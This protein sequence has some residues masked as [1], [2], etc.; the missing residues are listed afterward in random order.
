MSDFK[1]GD[2]VSWNS[3]A[4]ID[5]GTIIKINTKDFDYKGYTHHASPDRPQYEIKSDKSDHVAAHY[6]DKLKKINK[7]EK[8]GEL[9]KIKDGRVGGYLVGRKHSECNDDGDCGIKATNISTGQ[10][11]EVQANEVVITAPAVKDKTLHTFDG[12][13]MNNRQILSAINQSGGGVSFAEG[14][15]IKE[16]L[17][18]G[19]RINHFKFGDGTVIAIEDKGI[20]EVKFDN[21]EAKKLI[22]K[23][24]PIKKIGHTEDVLPLNIDSNISPKYTSIGELPQNEVPILKENKT[25]D[26][27]KIERKSREMQSVPVSGVKIVKETEK[28]YL[29][30]MDG[31]KGW[32]PKGW[33]DEENEDQIISFKKQ[34]Y[35]RALEGLKEKKE[36]SFTDS[37]NSEIEKETEK[38]YLIKV[39]INMPNGEEKKLDVWFPKS[40]IKL[41][42]GL[43]E[44]DNDFLKIKKAELEDKYGY[45]SAPKP[46]YIGEKSIGY[47]VSVYENLSEQSVR[48]SIYFPLSQVIKS[49]EDYLIP[50]WL[51][52]A[53]KEELYD[54]VKTGSWAMVSD[55]VFEI[56]GLERFVKEPIEIKFENGGEI[57][58]TPSVVTDE[59]LNRRKEARK[60][61]RAERLKMAT[62]LIALTA[63]KGVILPEKHNLSEHELNILN[64]FKGR[65]NKPVRIINPKKINGLTDKGLAYLTNNKGIK[66]LY[67]TRKGVDYLKNLPMR[68]FDIKKFAKGGVMT[69][70]E[71]ETIDINKTKFFKGFYFK[72]SNQ[73]LLNLAIYEYID[74]K[75]ELNDNE[76]DGEERQFISYFTGFG[77]LEKY[78]LSYSK[79]NGGIDL[80]EY[81]H[82]G[83]EKSFLTEFYTPIPVINAMWRLAYKYGYKDG[84]KV[85]EPSC[86]IGEFFKPVKHVNNFYANEINYYSAKIASIL[87][88]EIKIT[89]Q[90]FEKNFISRNESIGSNIKHNE[91]FN[92]VI[93]NPPYGKFDSLY[94]GMGE[95][96]YTEAKTWIEYFIFRGLDMLQSGGLL[97]YVIG[98]S[99]AIGGKL[100]LESSSS[101]IKKEIAKKAQLIDA[102]ILPN[103]IFETTGIVSEIIVLKKL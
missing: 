81:F 33:A 23:Y 98:T 21:G 11:I 22:Y 53:K 100:F 84:F 50:K 90:P 61:R 24:A 78:Y 97:I 44:F 13:K 35:K 103:K 37:P 102:Y 62:D 41:K 7:M 30:E 89:N 1:I 2:H 94:A 25:V 4:G 45:Y 88:P 99:N 96:A 47:N 85:F 3:E 58:N 48:R 42:D 12:K 56:D 95:A 72:Y 27:K 59:Y 63:K 9:E 16:P 68:L 5:S 75:E 71:T 83:W 46:S 49:G 67:L 70:G 52:N 29:I 19:D 76:F 91:Q 86:G 57:E 79:N 34:F 69:D 82:H 40:K 80:N 54:S 73:F 39:K 32:I 15:E 65:N 31:K 18:V 6:G 10:P 93:G 8:G 14:G 64:L 55:S 60:Q 17:A 101:P 38:A 20:V 51:Y 87:Y 77:G 36:A 92:L 28:A 66:E 43:I 74:T 26:T